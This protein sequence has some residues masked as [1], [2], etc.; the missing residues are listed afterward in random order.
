[1]ISI[2]SYSLTTVMVVASI[3]HTTSS[4]V[5]SKTIDY[6]QVDIGNVA[7]RVHFF[8]NWSNVCA[9]WFSIFYVFVKFLVKLLFLLLFCFTY[10]WIL[11]ETEHFL[12]FL[13]IFLPNFLKIDLLFFFWQVP[14]PS[15]QI[16]IPASF[17]ILRFLCSVSFS[18]LSMFFFFS[19]FL[20]LFRLTYVLPFP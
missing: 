6:P 7:W 14:F 20:H 12:K 19:F 8:H 9:R 2:T 18:E 1:M 15:I 13:N 3:S 16:A 10:N 11:T 4:I 5:I 17:S